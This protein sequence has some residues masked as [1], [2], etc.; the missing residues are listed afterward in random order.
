MDDDK[1]RQVLELIL[2]NRELLKFTGEDE[3]LVAKLWAAY[4]KK[5]KGEIRLSPEALAAALL[6]QYSSMNHLWENDK[7]WTLT[8]IAAIYDQKPK[9][10]GNNYSQIRKLLKIELWDDRFCRKDFADSNPFKEMAMLQTGFITTKN[11]AIQSCIPFTP[12]KKDKNDYYYDGMDFLDEGYVKDA[13]KCFKKA[14]AIDDEF[15]D[16]YNGLGTVHFWDD[17]Q[18]AKKYFEKAYELTKAHFKGKWPKEINWGILENRQYLR[19]IHYYGLVLWKEGNAEKAMELF[20]LL[21]SLN[22]YDNQGARYL[23]AE[24]YAGLKYEE[25]EENLAKEEKLLQEQNRKHRFWKQK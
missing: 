12:L 8:N 13:E 22:K 1:H 4:W 17:A 19:S 11:N 16:A 14:L 3:K 21:L 24:L 15:V 18:K 2:R 23:V 20:K 10:T 5:R 9:T 7:N 25:T 6:W